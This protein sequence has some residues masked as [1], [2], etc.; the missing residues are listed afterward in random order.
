LREKNDRRSGLILR[1][2]NSLIGL[3]SN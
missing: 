1:L 2:I 3:S